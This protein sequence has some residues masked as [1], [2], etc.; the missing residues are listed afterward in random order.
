VLGDPAMS[1]TPAAERLRSTSA[2]PNRAFGAMLVAMS[3]DKLRSEVLAL[4][5]EQRAELAHVL[6]ESLHEDADPSAETAWIEEL[7]RRAQAVADGSARLVDWEE[8][9]ERITAQLKA[10]REARTPR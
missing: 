8:A 9:R 5:A 4:P 3:T 1:T 6:L 10:R 2:L 7:D